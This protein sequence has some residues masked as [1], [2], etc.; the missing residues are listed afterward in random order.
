MESPF[1]T[2]EQTEKRNKISDNFWM[3]VRHINNNSSVNLN[4]Q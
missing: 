1:L 4:K 3:S 2:K